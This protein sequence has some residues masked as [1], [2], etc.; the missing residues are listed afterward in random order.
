MIGC[1]WNNSRRFLLVWRMF[2]FLQTTG[3]RFGK[4]KLYVNINGMR[5]GSYCS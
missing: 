3:L 1:S 2:Q 5:F 4:N